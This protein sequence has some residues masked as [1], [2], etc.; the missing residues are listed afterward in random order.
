MKKLDPRQLFAQ[1]SLL[2]SNVLRFSVLREESVVDL[3]VDYAA[4]ALSDWFEAR[5]RGVTRE[6][7]AAPP[8]DFRRLVFWGVSAL[9]FR[10]G[11]RWREPVFSWDG[12]RRVLRQHPPAITFAEVTGSEGAFCAEFEFETW[13]LVSF[14]FEGICVNRRMGTGA[15]DGG[16]DSSAYVDVETGEPFDFHEPFAEDIVM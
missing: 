10:P 16:D 15:G 14:T 2:E 13:G 12:L 11:P 8:R 1:I 3:V 9:R 6:E 5:A 4:E 7:Y